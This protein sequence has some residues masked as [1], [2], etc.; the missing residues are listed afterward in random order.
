M[1]EAGWILGTTSDQCA[2]LGALR[3][4]HWAPPFIQDT[5]DHPWVSLRPSGSSPSP[6]VTTGHSWAAFLTL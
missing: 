5:Q 2:S 1:A 4:P 6:M 3:D